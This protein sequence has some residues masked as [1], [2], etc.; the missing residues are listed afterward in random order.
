MNIFIF[1]IFIERKFK[2]LALVCA[3]SPLFMCVFRIKDTGWIF[4]DKLHYLNNINKDI[5]GGVHGQH[6]MVDPRQN[7]RPRGPVHQ[8][9]INE[10]LMQ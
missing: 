7:L 4:A 2:G 3:L 5:Y 1:F 8:C 9:A 10:D 6:E